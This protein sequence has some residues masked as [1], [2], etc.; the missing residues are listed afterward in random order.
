MLKYLILAVFVSANDPYYN[1]LTIDGGGIKGVIT[2]TCIG[3][4]EEYAY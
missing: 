3:R 1:I 2:V 4:M